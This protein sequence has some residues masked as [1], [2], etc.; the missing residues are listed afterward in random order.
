[1]CCG[2]DDNEEILLLCDGCSNSC[3]TECI[4]LASVP[5]G[6]WFCFDCQEDRT[7][8]TQSQPRRRTNR[9]IAQS[10][11]VPRQGQSPDPW[12]RVWQ[13]VWTNLNLD[14]DF[15]FDE[16]RDEAAERARAQRREFHQWERRFRVAQHQGGAA[17]FRDTAS[18]LLDRR[19]RSAAQSAP[20]ES[21]EEIRAWNA[22]D[23]AREVSSST[24]TSR[25]NKRK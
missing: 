23:K 5:A 17:R 20:S 25:R 4:G 10:R 16:E 6:S 2:R 19:T 3:H 9:T 15:P 8:S 22:F 18:A 24:G 11:A 14:L 7:I 12:A 1:M 21:Q 13:S